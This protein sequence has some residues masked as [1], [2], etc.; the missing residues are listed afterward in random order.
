MKELK[1]VTFEQGSRDNLFNSLDQALFVCTYSTGI[2]IDAILRGKPIYAESP[3]SFV[4][5]LSTPLENAVNK[6]FNISDRQPLLNKLSYVQ[7]SLDE[8]R[9]G[10]PWKHLVLDI[11]KF[12]NLL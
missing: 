4:Y 1:N 5:E 2:G 10:L 8:I 7:W 12:S 3:A 9:D 11:H 6:N